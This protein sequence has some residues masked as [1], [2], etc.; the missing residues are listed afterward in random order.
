MHLNGD[1]ESVS[2][3]PIMLNCD[4]CESRREAIRRSVVV[5]VT[6]RADM[7][8]SEFRQRMSDKQCRCMS[9]KSFRLSR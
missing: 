6:H 2:S 9:A 8:F 4:G 3:F 7:Q 1:D 5:S